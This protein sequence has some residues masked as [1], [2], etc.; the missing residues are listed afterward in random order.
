MLTE[1]STLHSLS[2]SPCVCALLFFIAPQEFGDFF[3]GLNVPS[4]R[5]SDR[6]S[7]NWKTFLTKTVAFTLVSLSNSVSSNTEHLPLKVTRSQPAFTV[8][9]TC[10]HSEG[11]R[12]RKSF[13][14]LKHEQNPNR[15]PN[16]SCRD[17]I[18]QK[19]SHAKPNHSL[20]SNESIL[21]HIVVSPA[22]FL[23]I[24]KSN[25]FFQLFN[26]QTFQF[27]NFLKRLLPGTNESLIPSLRK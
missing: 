7:A 8:I 20:S 25:W 2:T 1:Q 17:F 24:H 11:G 10:T 16:Q 14:I 18:F 19:P 21:Q 26:F 5:E 9:Y 22:C 3:L 4:I 23:Y 15:V 12:Q 6:L 27:T 13:E